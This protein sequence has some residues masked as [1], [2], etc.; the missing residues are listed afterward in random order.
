MR[1]QGFIPSM[2]SPCQKRKISIYKYFHKNQFLLFFVKIKTEKSQWSSQMKIKYLLYAFIKQRKN[3]KE[4]N[5]SHTPGI[6]RLI[7]SNDTQKCCFLSH[8]WV[9][10]HKYSSHSVCPWEKSQVK[11]FT[12]FLTPPFRITPNEARGQT[13]LNY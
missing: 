12:L 3:K 4:Q 9:T 6:K 11:A 1:K 10:W 13:L 2:E 5:K 8:T 7:P